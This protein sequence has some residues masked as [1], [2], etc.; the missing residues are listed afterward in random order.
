M[1]FIQFLFLI[2][3]KY[4]TLSQNDVQHPRLPNINKSKPDKFGHRCVKGAKDTGLKYRN[5]CL[6]HTKTYNTFI[7]QIEWEI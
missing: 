4:F 7:V 2:T 5:G 6:H 3:L 1:S